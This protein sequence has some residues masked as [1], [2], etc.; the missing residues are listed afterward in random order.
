MADAS[1]MEAA[2]LSPTPAFRLA[3]RLEGTAADA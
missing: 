1:A 2:G 3:R